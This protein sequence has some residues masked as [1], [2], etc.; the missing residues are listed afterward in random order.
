M[1][2]FAAMMLPNQVFLS[3]VPK[4]SSKIIDGFVEPGYAFSEVCV[5]SCISLGWKILGLAF[6][7]RPCRPVGLA[8]CQNGLWKSAIRSANPDLPHAREGLEEHESRPLCIQV[9]LMK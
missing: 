6:G 5:E 4:T 7:L 3:P 9:R 1:S 2:K 8:G